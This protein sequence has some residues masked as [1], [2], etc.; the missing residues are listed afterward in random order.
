MLKRGSE[1][2]TSAAAVAVWSLEVPERAE[3]AEPR[4]S[5]QVQGSGV[6]VNDHG[7]ARKRSLL[8]SVPL[9]EVDEQATV[10][11]PAPSAVRDQAVDHGGVIGNRETRQRGQGPLGPHFEERGAG[12]TEDAWGKPTI[13]R[14]TPTVPTQP[15]VKPLGW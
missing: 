8:R 10:A 5:E 12:C 11:P 4:P 1:V 13:A 3:L 9:R 15:G 14:Q 6:A 2:P 7:E